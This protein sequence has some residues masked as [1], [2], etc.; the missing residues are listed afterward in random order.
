[1]SVRSVLHRVECCLPAL[2]IGAAFLVPADAAEAQVAEQGYRQPSQVLVDIVDAPPTPSV[3]TG[4]DNEWMLLM[5]SP[6]LPPIADLAQRE[7]RIAGTRIAP[8]INGPSR[9]TGYVNAWFK[10]IADGREVAISGLP[11]DPKLGDFEWSPDGSRVAFTHTT[12]SAIEL[13]VADVE[14]GVATRLIDRALNTVLAGGPEWLSDGRT[15]LVTLVP[16]DRRPEP[17]AP[18]VPTGPTIQQNIDKT[19]P[20]RTYQDL[21]ENPHDAELFEYYATAQ[22]AAVRLDGSMAEIGEPGI[23]GDFSP[24]P[25]ASYV[26]VERVHRPFSY[27]VPWYR[28]PTRIEVLD[29]SG[30]PVHL[31]ADLPLQEEVPV[32][33]GSVPTGPRSV[34]WRADARATLYWVEALDGGDAGRPAEERDRVFMHAAPFAG[35]P[36]PVITLG[37]RYGGIMWGDDDLALVAESWWRT[38]QMRLWRFEPTNLGAEPALVMDRS[39]EDRYNDPGSP[40]MKMNERGRA[41][42]LTADGGRTLFLSGQGASPEGDRPFLDRYDLRTGETERLFRSEAPYYERV[43][44]VLD[45]RGRTILTLRESQDDPPNFFVRDLRRDRLRQVTEF[46]NPTPQLAGMQKELI[47][48]ARADGVTLS[49]TVYLP[50]GYEPA[51][52]GPLPLFVWAYPREFKDASAAAQVVGSPHRFTRLGGWSTPIWVALGYAVLDGATMPIVGE[53]DAEPNDTYVE[54]LVASAE[55]AVNEMVRRGVAEPGRAGIGGHSYGAFMTANVLTWSDAYAAGI[56]RSGAYNRSLT[57]F[58]FQAEE[59][60]FWEAPEVYFRM[61]PFMN[62]DKIDEPILLI[63]GEADNNSGTFPIQSERYYHALKGLGKTARLVM[64]PHESHGYRSRESILHM[65]WEMETWLDRYVKGAPGEAAV[66]QQ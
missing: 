28:F 29:M 13:W 12:G 43:V 4:P 26:L 44:D 64:L 21:L 1:M 38:R 32:P 25:D 66:S 57:P 54:Q 11:T 36:Q 59:R 45:E 8:Q 48:Y 22:L 31:V 3:R 30:A 23:I 16:Q 9:R 47:Q 49:G 62:T 2:V 14:T 20:A 10:R 18:T 15:I 52:D 40:V 17:T 5:Q 51:R 27:L 33:F 41:V 55:A 58:G 6:S 7:L 60:T 61:S 34:S 37:Y 56:A 53:G 42:L 24:S 39:Y 63:H 46:P 35:D 65:L 50:E 19:A